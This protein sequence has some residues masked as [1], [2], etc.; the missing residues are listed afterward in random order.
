MFQKFLSM[1]GFTY[2]TVI[3]AGMFLLVCAGYL[4]GV[5]RMPTAVEEAY[6]DGVIVALDKGLVPLDRIFH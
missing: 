3:V 1:V 4:M 5:V 2:F 6:A